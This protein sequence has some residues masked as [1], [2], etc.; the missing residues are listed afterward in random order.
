MTDSNDSNDENLEHTSRYV[1]PTDIPPDGDLDDILGNA[2]TAPEFDVEDEPFEMAPAPDPSQYD[3]PT[4]TGQ[5]HVPSVDYTEFVETERD[6]YEL[7]LEAYREALSAP[8]NKTRLKAAKDV[9]QIYTS[10]RETAERREFGDTGQT[11]NTQINISVDSVRNA[12]KSALYGMEG[13][14]EE[15]NDAKRNERYVGRKPDARRGN[16]RSSERVSSSESDSHDGDT[17]DRFRT[18]GTK[19]PSKT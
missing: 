9:V 15:V 16:G 5:L 6:L 10:R 12:L 3:V 8:D 1:P 11:N 7:A 4:G 14:I 18:P 13:G 17:P 19:G 2:A